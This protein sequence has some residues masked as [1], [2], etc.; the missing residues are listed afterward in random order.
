MT[1]KRSL[2]GPR[3]SAEQRREHILEAALPVFAAYG[4]HGASTLTIA[5][6]AGISETYIFRLFGTK[7]ELFLAVVERVHGQVMSVYRSVLE[8]HPDQPLEAIQVAIRHAPVSQDKLLLLL[9]AYAACHDE[10]IQRVVRERFTD[11]YS[12]VAHKVEDRAD[13]QTFFAYNMLSMITLAM[14][15]T[16]LASLAQGPATSLQE[17]G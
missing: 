1:R 11:M 10:D 16:D 12:Y 6:H 5:E 3:L 14:G 2:P 8:N 13:V 9:Q 17:G 15:I 4:L 7:K